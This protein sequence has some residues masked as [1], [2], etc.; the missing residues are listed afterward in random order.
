MQSK[1]AI[2]P[3]P[4][5]SADHPLHILEGSENGAAPGHEEGPEHE[6]GEVNGGGNRKRRWS[7]QE[8]REVAAV[9]AKQ[10]RKQGLR[11]VPQVGD[12]TGRQFLGDFVREAQ[13]VL[14]IERRRINAPLHA[15]S[16]IFFKLVEDALAVAPDTT[17]KPVVL[18]EANKSETNGAVAP[19]APVHPVPPVGYA[20]VSEAQPLANIP[21]VVLM[22]EV[23]N[24]LLDALDSSAKKI[25]ILEDSNK[26]LLEEFATVSA[27]QERIMRRLADHDTALG[28]LPAQV[29]ENLPR[30]AIVSCRKDEMDHIE[31]GAEKHGLKLDFRLYEQNSAPRRIDADW[32][33]TMR[34][35]GHE[36]QDQ[37]NKSIPSGQ[38]V[39]TNGGVS[40]VINQLCQWFKPGFKSVA[41]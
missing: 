28:K 29:R 13:I 41:S 38:S 15:F 5:D 16:P 35:G 33:V 23:N 19:A 31:R 36:W 21:L 25:Q 32:A 8:M 20:I 22:R 2:L 17:P 18:V 37:V 27:S 30:V 3:E 24:R 26:F 39:F 34:F 7:I 12:F 6:E 4:P 40:S 10:L 9:V 11:H 14:P 1:A